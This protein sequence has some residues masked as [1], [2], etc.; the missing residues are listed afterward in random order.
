MYRPFRAQL[1]SA[2]IAKARTRIHQEITHGRFR[3]L[4]CQVHAVSP[5]EPHAAGGVTCRRRP[6][7]RELH[8]GVLD[9]PG[10]L[11]ELKSLLAMPDRGLRLFGGLHCNLR[12]YA[13]HSR[14]SRTAHTA[15][16]QTR[17]R[18]ADNRIASGRTPDITTSFATKRRDSRSRTRRSTA[19]L[20]VLRLPPVGPP[21][22]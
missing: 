4:Q 6:L 7:P 9:V 19:S 20:A 17:G 2:A 10:D 14:P 18:N 22:A 21:S 11:R 16:L 3:P 8:L 1:P 5:G 12:R 15:R 13:T